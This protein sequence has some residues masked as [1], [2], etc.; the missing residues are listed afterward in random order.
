MGF[1]TGH[2]AQFGW[3]PEATAGTAITVTKF[4]PHISESFQ[5]KLNRAQGEGRYGSTNGFALLSRHVTTTRTVEG[6]VEIELTDT[7]L[8]TLWRA[9]LGASTTASTLLSGTAY[10]AVFHP[11][12][13]KSTGSSL[14]L[15]VGRPQTDGTVRAHTYNG[16]KV[17]SFEFGG[18]VTDPLN[19]TFSFDAWNETTG[20]ALATASYVAGQ[21]QFTGAD[22]TVSVG[23]T[24][25][26]TASVV[27]LSGASTLAGVRSVSVKGTN[28]L[29]TERFYAGSSGVKSEQQVNG[30]REYTVELELDYVDRTVLY[31]LFVANT[32]TP[33]K[34]SWAKS[35]AITGSY[36]PTLEVILSG[37]K[38]T[39]ATIDDNGTE[40]TQQK[41]TF[42]AL[43]DGTNSP[44][45][46]RTISTDSSL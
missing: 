27:S 26:T 36:Y 20:T 25:S 23:G 24:A 19:A 45:Q 15:Q 33:L 12:D 3:V 22:L 2:I 4:Q 21:Q 5:L 17:T 40:L 31:D 41:V 6:D 35:T 39:D 42:T 38:I 1:V 43:Y 13:Q 7:G 9:A 11:G 37:A 8:G 30:F 32:T 44:F 46:I 10:Q 34:L 29:D 16:A 14:T 28:P 18:G